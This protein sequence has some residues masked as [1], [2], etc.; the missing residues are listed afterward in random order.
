VTHHLAFWASLACA[1]DSSRVFDITARP[2]N[3]QSVTPALQVTWQSMNARRPALGVIVENVSPTELYE[4]VSLASSQDPTRVQA[5]SKR[6][7]EMLEMFGT[8]DGLHEIAAQKTVPLPVRQQSIIQF[9]NAALT[10]WRSRKLAVLLPIH[11][12]SSLLT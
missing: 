4:V 11:F 8:Y 5:S 12:L 7:K 6:L 2:E 9:K 1:N 10:H 3:S